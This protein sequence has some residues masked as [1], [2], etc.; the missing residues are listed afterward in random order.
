MD[1]D[2]EEADAIATGLQR[3]FREYDYQ[4]TGKGMAWGMFL[5]TI[6]SIELR[7]LREWREERDA[8]RTAMPRPPA[9]PVPP[10]PPM[11]APMPDNVHTLMVGPHGVPPVAG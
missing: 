5:M 1:L 3:L 4:P 8:R 10:V 7:H 2:K 11:A 9:P 6:A